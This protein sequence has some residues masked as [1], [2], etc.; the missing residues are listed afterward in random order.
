MDEYG[1]VSSVRRSFSLNLLFS[2]LFSTRSTLV[3][4]RPLIPRSCQGGRDRG[5]EGG[6]EGGRAGGREGGRDEG[7]EGGTKEGRK[8]GREGGREGGRDITQWLHAGH[9]HCL[10]AR[11]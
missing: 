6:R 5:R 7:R 2:C 11:R 8:G 1:S 10:P 9:A 4:W 3:T